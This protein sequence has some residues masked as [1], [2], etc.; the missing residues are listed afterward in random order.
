ML[1]VPKVDRAT[2]DGLIRPLAAQRPD[3]VVALATDLPTFAAL[4]ALERELDVPIVSSNQT[5]LWAGLRAV[6][7]RGAL[8]GLGRLFEAG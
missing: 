3:A 1:D 6:G 2:L 8:P 4:G 5:L 7:W